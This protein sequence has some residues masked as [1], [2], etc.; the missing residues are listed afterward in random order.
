MEYD[1]RSERY[2]RQV[3]LKE[4]GESGQQKLRS[5][6][7]LVAGAGGLGCPVLQYLAAAG[8]GTIG[9]IDHDT[10]SLSN[11]HRQVLFTTA[12]VGQPKV[13]AA[14]GRLADMNPGIE[15]ISYMHRLATHNA[16]DILETF[17]VIVDATDNF[18]TRYL[19]GDAC[20]LLAKPLVQGAVSRY[21][22]QLAVFNCHTDPGK[23]PVCYRDLFPLPPE[24]GEIANCAEAGVLGVLPAII[25]SLQ[26]AEV[27]KLLT[28]IGESLAGKLQTYHMLRNEWFTWDITPNA[29]AESHMP[30]TRSAFLETVYE[31]DCALN[32]FEEI[33][34]AGF[35]RL[36][37]EEDVVV[38]DVREHGEEP[39]LDECA[40]LRIPLSELQRSLDVSGVPN[41]ITVCQSGKRSLVAARLLADAFKE[42]TI[43]SLRGGIVAL[44][45]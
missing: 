14:A 41:I 19:I 1:I 45:Q 21:E 11:L 30:Q 43:Y 15:V 42:K 32:G 40:H 38:I 36:C 22:G 10:V 4:L 12:D 9:I 5:S 29:R 16:L 18:P 2:H 8:V 35:T 44:K 7:V 24:N 6:K 26:A 20:S 33:D 13:T 37:R 31:A 39:L 28:G 25:G 34:A 3:I 17:D 23:R 27:I